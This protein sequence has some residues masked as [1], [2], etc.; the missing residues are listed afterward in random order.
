LGTDL[1]PG[2]LL[3]MI[4][5]CASKIEGMAAAAIFN[6][7]FMAAVIARLLHDFLPQDFMHI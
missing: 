4:G 6:A 3:E 1:I 2:E 7:V 5:S